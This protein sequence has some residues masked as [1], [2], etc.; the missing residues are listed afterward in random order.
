MFFYDFLSIFNRSGLKFSILIMS[1][2]NVYFVDISHL[3][4]FREFSELNLTRTLSF[5][6][7]IENK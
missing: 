5:L 1:V 7:T 4:L 6:S 2:L 3:Y